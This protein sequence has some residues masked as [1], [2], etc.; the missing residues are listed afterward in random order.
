M[1][2]DC[3]VGILTD[4]RNKPHK[5]RPELMP[6]FIQRPDEKNPSYHSGQE[7]VKSPPALDPGPVDLE[8]ALADR[9]RA[10]VPHQEEYQY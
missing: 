10:V 4:I 8:D 9:Q 7:V 3:I 6:G 1:T 2:I 5:G